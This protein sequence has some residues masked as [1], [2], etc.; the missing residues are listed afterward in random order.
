MKWRIDLI[1]AVPFLW[2]GYGVWAIYSKSF[3]ISSRTAM[4][5]GE[6]AQWFGAAFIA[7]A[8]VAHVMI[9]P[10]YEGNALRRK[11]FIGLGSGLAL[12]LFFIGCYTKL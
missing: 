12:V 1:Q 4:E 6:I 7:V 8:F 11:V 9:N 2:A 10:V 3:R 5:T